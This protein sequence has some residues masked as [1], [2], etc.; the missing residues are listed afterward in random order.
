MITVW[1]FL[2]KLLA[3]KEQ[4]YDIIA[5]ANSIKHSVYDIKEDASRF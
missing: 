3:E 5:F 1:I 4:Q 2:F